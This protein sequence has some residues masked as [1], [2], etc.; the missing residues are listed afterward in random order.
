MSKQAGKMIRKH[1]TN[2]SRVGRI[3]LIKKFNKIRR[4]SD[5]AFTRELVSEFLELL[6]KKHRERSWVGQR[7][8]G[9]LG[10][11]SL[12]SLGLDKDLKFAT[13]WLTREI[14]RINDYIRLTLKIQDLVL[15]A[16]WAQAEKNVDEFTY[17]QGW[18]FWALELK[19]I[20]AM[21]RG[22]VEAVKKLLGMVRS[23]SEGRVV[24]LIAKVI[25]ERVDDKYSLDSFFSRWRNGISKSTKS[26]NTAQYVIYR[27]MGQVDHVEDG[28]ARCLCVD[29]ATSIFDCYE[30]LIDVCGTLIVERKIDRFPVIEGCINELATKGI[31][32]DR[33]TK[34]LLLMGAVTPNDLIRDNAVTA[35]DRFVARLVKKTKDTYTPVLGADQLDGTDNLIQEQR[36]QLMRLGIN[37]KSLSI[38]PALTEYAMQAGRSDSEQ[39]AHLPWASLIGPI[40]FVEQVLSPDYIRTW[41]II[42]QLVL[43]D[44]IRNES[45]SS[46]LSVKHGEL[47]QN[48]VESLDPVFLTWLCNYLVHVGRHAEV[49]GAIAHLGTLSNYWLNTS[50]KLLLVNKSRSGA[51]SDA[52]DLATNEVL[53]HPKT[54]YQYPLR[55]I[56]I[57]ASYKDFKPFDP[58]LVAL[59]SHYAALNTVSS[60]K[61]KIGH[62]C[63]MACK[64]ILEL[65]G[66]TYI[67]DQWNDLPSHE[68]YKFVHFLNHVWTEDNLSLVGFETS[69]QLRSERIEAMHLLVLIDP[70]N[71]QGYAAI[72]RQ[73]TLSNTLWEGITHVDGSRIFVNEP[74]IARW[75]KGELMQ[76][77]LKWQELRGLRL[78]GDVEEEIS[79]DGTAL[80]E[81]DSQLANVDVDVTD[82]NKLLISIVER[83]EAKF[84][85]DTLDGLECYLSARIRHGTLRG[86]ILGPMEGA[87]LL[88][89]GQGKHEIEGFNIS[90]T[91]R[92]VVED[93]CGRL[94]SIVD[95]ALKTKVRLANRNNPD[96]LLNTDRPDNYFSNAIDKMGGTKIEFTVFISLCFESFWELL[97][98]SRASTRDYFG[99]NF[100]SEIQRYFSEAITSLCKITSDHPLNAALLRL[101]VETCSQCDSVG[102]WFYNDGQVNNRSFT[103]NEAIAITEKA[104]KIT[105]RKFNA[106]VLTEP[107]DWL[108]IPLTGIGLSAIVE[109][110]HV[111][112]ENAWKH[113]GFGTSHYTIRIAVEFDAENEVLRFDVNSPVTDERRAILLAGQ[114]AEVQ[115]KTQENLGI[116][117]V[118]DA[119]G[120][121]LPKLARMSARVDNLVYPKPFSIDLNDNFHVM[122]CIPLHRRGNAYD[123]YYQ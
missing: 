2:A 76:D 32:D 116:N 62:V 29:V 45:T 3:D 7:L 74:S 16:D 57:D 22:G 42:E 94:K 46:L 20:C 65:G 19:F 106:K 77:F 51:T 60:E 66:R 58:F 15:S 40:I 91:Q 121:G 80:V 48:I 87:G 41:N 13:H 92:A 37:L 118:S 108:E 47:E 107:S 39:A 28:L 34:I 26:Q 109:G 83:L 104:A 55:E 17:A 113:S 12:V 114:L 59:V 101:S 70:D 78:S 115:L 90:D 25:S 14:N 11:S 85:M 122:A 105:Y 9:D 75:A 82:E 89:S 23:K 64:K 88:T 50:R 8:L 49:K 36:I 71:A 117:S 72:I 67:Y 35:T 24:G 98:P 4:K 44:S 38:G 52:L 119:G 43:D 63:R 33:L 53:H 73:L 69:Q 97:R 102:R 54:L 84:L 1:L 10:Y 81:S 95:V 5:D 79:Y 110:L 56:F 31:K 68:R 30:T 96:G 93:L 27:A 111:I 120:S 18:S 6:N 61:E 100:K 21:K 112:M 103:V 86:A 99:M 123:A